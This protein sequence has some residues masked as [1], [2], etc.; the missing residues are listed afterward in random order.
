MF[1]L[2]GQMA[3]LVWELHGGVAVRILLLGPFHVVRTLP[4]EQLI[5]YYVSATYKYS[6]TL[7]LAFSQ[8]LAFLK[9]LLIL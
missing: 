1:N 5:R 9:K 4:C 2:N 8:R 7:M 6:N 3:E